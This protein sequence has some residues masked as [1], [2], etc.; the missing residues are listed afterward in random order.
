MHIADDIGEWLNT[1]IGRGLAIHADLWRPETKGGYYVVFCI[2]KLSE[3]PD[4][5]SWR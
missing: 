1:V 3:G 4:K 2:Y 5:A